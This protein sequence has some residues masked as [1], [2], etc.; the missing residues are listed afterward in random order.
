M[1]DLPR[2]RK[3]VSAAAAALDEHRRRGQ[4]FEFLRERLRSVDVE[5]VFGKLEADLSLGDR[6]A[7]SEA[8]LRAVDE[9]EANLRRAGMVLQVA[10][11]E[12]DLFQ[13]H[14]RAAHGEFAWQARESLERLRRE[15]RLSGQVTMEV[16]EDWICAHV[17]DYRRWKET[18]IEH[19][20]N[21][22]MAKHMFAAWESRCASLRK[23]AELVER[24][25]GVDPSLMDRRDGKRGDDR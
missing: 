10:I 22:T 21:R 9:A 16:V 15:S 20:R 25:R 7:N 23:Q 3:L 12:A 4:R 11:E 13:L 5:A 1:S 2:V 24:R 19:E 18:E 6:R 17:P 14:L 8:I